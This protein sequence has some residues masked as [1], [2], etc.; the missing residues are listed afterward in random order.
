MDTDR[1]VHGSLDDWR[2]VSKELAV[3]VQ[4]IVRYLFLI[5]CSQ[6]QEVAESLCWRAAREQ[7]EDNVS[8]QVAP[9]SS[10]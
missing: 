3:L 4:H 8:A 5:L 6:K 10:W 9:E 7:R 1:Q 2:G